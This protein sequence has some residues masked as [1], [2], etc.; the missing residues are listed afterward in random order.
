[1]KIRLLTSCDVTLLEGRLTTQSGVDS[2]F[3]VIGSKSIQLPT[4][5]E[6][7]PEKGL[8]EILAPKRSDEPL[9]ERMRS[10]YE[11]DRLDFLDVE[12]SQIRSPTMEPE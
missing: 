10:R 6:A 11:G 3:V 9:D 7:I 4:Q 5:V 1:M 8:V 12:K 2:P